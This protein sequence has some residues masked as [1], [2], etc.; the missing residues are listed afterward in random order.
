M[1]ELCFIVNVDWFFHSHRRPLEKRLASTYK[2]TVIAGYSGIQADY[3]IVP[4]EVS[5][6]V[7]TIRGI[8]QLYR[9]VKELDRDT[10]CIIVSPV[11]IILCHFLFRTRRKL[12]YNFSGLGFLRSKSAIF[13]TLIFWSFLQK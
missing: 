6:R 7:P 11:M 9:K 10:I 4:F 1:K 3:K 13:R 2:T 5:S 8:Y 12:I